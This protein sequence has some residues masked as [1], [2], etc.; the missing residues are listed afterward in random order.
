MVGSGIGS[1]QIGECP[2][3]GLVVRRDVI[4]DDGDRGK[5]R[6]TG[7]CRQGDVHRIVTDAATIR[8]A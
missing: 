8:P 6:S 1:R 2:V 7:D 4:P 5:R 3:V